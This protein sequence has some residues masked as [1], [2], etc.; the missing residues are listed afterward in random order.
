MDREQFDHVVATKGE[1]EL[2]Y[3]FRNF[4]APVLEEWVLCHCRR[5]TAYPVSRVQSIY[6]ETLA[7]DSYAEKINSDFYKT[8]YRARWYDDPAQ[9]AKQDCGERTIF[10][11]KKMNGVF[12][13]L[14]SRST[15]A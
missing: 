14:K 10:L 4:Q 8:K 1:F 5:D 7:R 13:R 2:K 11:D 6:L 12:K 15:I 3:A 9:T